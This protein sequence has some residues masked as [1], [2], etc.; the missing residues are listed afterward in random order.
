M[1]RKQGPSH[2]VSYNWEK[3]CMLFQV[4]QPHLFDP[5]MPQNFQAQVH[6][7]T[8]HHL[9]CC[10]AW[11]Q[12]TF[13]C[14]IWGPIFSLVVPNTALS[15]RVYKSFYVGTNQLQALLT[16]SD[17][18]TLMAK[19]PTLNK[20]KDHAYL[21]SCSHTLQFTTKQNLPNSPTPVLG[22]VKRMILFPPLLMHI[23]GL[24]FNRAHLGP[25]D[26]ANFIHLIFLYRICSK[27][28]FFFPQPKV[29][30]RQR[31][32]FVHHCSYEAQLAAK[33]HQKCL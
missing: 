32:N 33:P 24:L 16:G 30:I 17:K 26:M 22:S 6:P 12:M 9:P 21:W 29:P 5:E 3:P 23:S 2:W 31:S 19:R 4:I 1:N 28:N 8:G 14:Q 13:L 11:V 25:K 7:P 27:H 18:I 20:C 15:P 10:I